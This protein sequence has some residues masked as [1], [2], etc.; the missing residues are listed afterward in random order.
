M[1]WAGGVRTQLQRIRWVD[2]E[3]T[4]RDSC[5]WARGHAVLSIGWSRLLLTSNPY[6]IRT[7]SEYF[8]RPQAASPFLQSPL[9]R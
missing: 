7:P 9:N 1:G 5:R 6:D 3:G 8:G 2:V 4:Q